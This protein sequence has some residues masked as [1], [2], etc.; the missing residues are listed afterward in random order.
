MYAD[1]ARQYWV[2]PFAGSLLAAAFYSL[3][4]YFRYWRLSPG[5]DA[6]H[7]A[8]SPDPAPTHEEMAE[9]AVNV[10]AAPADSGSDGDVEA[11]RTSGAGFGEKGARRE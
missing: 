10:G 2:G 9:I 5:Q 11:G 3:L 8:A 1:G 7:E 4:K 6:V